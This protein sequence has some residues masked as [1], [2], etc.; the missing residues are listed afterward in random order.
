M[1]LRPRNFDINSYKINRNNLLMDA[2]RQRMYKYSENITQKNLGLNRT[3]TN[4][5]NNIRQ[6]NNYFNYYSSNNKTNDHIDIPKYNHNYFER[7]NN[8]KADYIS[9]RITSNN[10][11]PINHNLPKK[12]TTISKTNNLFRRNNIGTYNYNKFIEDKFNL[13]AK[14]EK[15]RNENYEKDL[16]NLNNKLGIKNNYITNYI[17]DFSKIES[18]DYIRDRN[19]KNKLREIDEINKEI[20]KI[21]GNNKGKDLEDINRKN[22]FLYK[23][24]NN[25][26]DKTK[27]NDLFDYEK[28]L[29]NNK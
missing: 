25:D 8:R 12:E 10:T 4:T 3:N 26:D 23:Y 18:N 5:G 24:N 22:D 29:K 19:V 21:K 6:S 11:N 7:M 27:K 17:P 16:F 28:K 9:N 15:L 1:S 20:N 13:N 2:R 14:T